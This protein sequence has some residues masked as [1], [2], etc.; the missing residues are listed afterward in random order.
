MEEKTPHRQ[1]GPA[2]RA[3]D[4]AYWKANL[5]LILL[6]LVIWAFVSLGCSVLFVE[7]LNAFQI[8]QIPFGFWMGHQGSIYVFVLLIAIYVWQMSRLDDQHGSQLEEEQQ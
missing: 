7:Q 5:R 2:Q 8:G 4:K 1:H 6:L 3:R